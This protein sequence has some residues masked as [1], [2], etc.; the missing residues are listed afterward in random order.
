MIHSCIILLLLNVNDFY[1]RSLSSASALITAG[2]AAASQWGENIFVI[3]E[4]M[5]LQA[6]TTFRIGGRTRDIIQRL[7]LAPGPEH[8]FPF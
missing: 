7:V 8:I 5:N 4:T 6:H 3:W 2:L 1:S